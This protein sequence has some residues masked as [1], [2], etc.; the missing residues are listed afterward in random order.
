MDRYLSQFLK[1][2]SDKK[3]ILL[4]GPRQSGKTTLVKQ[5]F[6]NDDY[7]NFDASEDREAILK[8]NGDGMLT[9]LFLMNFTKCLIGKGG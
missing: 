3:I 2:D 5:I 9:V 6:E 7:L 8:K 4:T 1:K